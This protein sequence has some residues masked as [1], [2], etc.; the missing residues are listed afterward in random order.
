MRQV[1]KDVKPGLVIEKDAPSIGV[2]DMIAENL[3]KVPLYILG[4][5][6]VDDYER[7]TC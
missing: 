4:E 3:V 7:D 2:V 5:A 6:L 1:K